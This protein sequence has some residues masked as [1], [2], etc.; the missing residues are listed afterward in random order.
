MDLPKKRHICVNNIHIGVDLDHEI[1][2]SII[3]ACACISVVSFSCA[4]ISVFHLA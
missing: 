3:N 4:C 2:Q 1:I